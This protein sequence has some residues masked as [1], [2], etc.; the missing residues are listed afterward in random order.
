[1][2]L[3]NAKE[4]VGIGNGTF[5]EKKAVFRRSPFVLTSQVAKWR[6]WGPHQIDT[7]QTALADMAPAVWAI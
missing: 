1:M 6:D 2:V 4:N 5:L 7:R 3:L